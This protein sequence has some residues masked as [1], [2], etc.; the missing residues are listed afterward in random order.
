MYYHRVILR[1]VLVPII[2]NFSSCGKE[3]SW[4]DMENKNHQRGFFLLRMTFPSLELWGQCSTRVIFLLH[5]KVEFD[6]GK[7]LG[8][9]RDILKRLNKYMIWLPL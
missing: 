5:D 4:Q 2:V 1:F 8:L 3:S 9:I 6:T 7:G